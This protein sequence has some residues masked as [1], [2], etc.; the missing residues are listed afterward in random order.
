SQ[1]GT[2]TRARLITVK[3]IIAGLSPLEIPVMAGI[4]IGVKTRDCLF[5]RFSR[6]S[7][8]FGQFCQSIG[9]YHPRRDALARSAATN[10]PLHLIIMVEDQPRRLVEIGVTVWIEAMKGSGQG[11]IIGG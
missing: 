10:R 6:N 1:R 7:Q 5:Q 8:I 3:P 11:R 2:G 9:G 4:G